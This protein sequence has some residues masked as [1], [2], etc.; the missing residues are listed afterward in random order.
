ML[1]FGGWGRGANKN[2][3]ALLNMKCVRHYDLTYLGGKEAKQD[4][5]G[6]ERFSNN[7]V[8]TKGKSEKLVDIKLRETRNQSAQNTNK[9][10][11]T[12]KQTKKSHCGKIHI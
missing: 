4:W 10:S 9:N 7:S 6:E 2:T 11:K 1:Y 5:K 12:N 3:F 8:M